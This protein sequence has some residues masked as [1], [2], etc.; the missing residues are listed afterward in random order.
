MGYLIFIIIVIFICFSM[1]WYT[2]GIMFSVLLILI[3]GL[4][5]N[6]VQNEEKKINKQDKEE[7]EKEV[8]RKRIMREVTIP[9][10]EKSR[11]ELINKY[12]NPIKTIILQEYDLKEEIIVFK[13]AHRVWICG[14]DIPMKSILGCRVLDDEIIMRGDIISTTQV[15]NNDMLTR[16]L[17]GGA[18][19]GEAGAVVGGLSAEKKSIFIHEDDDVFHNYTI[20][21]N[22]D[23]L[24]NPI[25]KIALDDDNELVTEIIGLLNVII[26]RNQRGGGKNN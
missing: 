8:A 19:F 20:V 12:G 6:T 1:G 2:A 9:A 18:L 4:S 3:I 14:Q 25:I 11:R 24:D 5:L 16:G 17:V 7:K 26:S 15:D 21:V 10:Y 13:E 22:V 23:S